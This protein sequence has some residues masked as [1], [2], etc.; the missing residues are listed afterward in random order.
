MSLCNYHYKDGNGGIVSFI[1]PLSELEVQLNGFDYL[2]T[3]EWQE[4]DCLMEDFERDIVANDPE[5]LSFL[6]KEKLEIMNRS[7]HIERA[8]EDARIASLS[9]GEDVDLKL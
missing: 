1:R 2:M 3:Y 4:H 8:R 9:Q 7:Y 5:L 6:T